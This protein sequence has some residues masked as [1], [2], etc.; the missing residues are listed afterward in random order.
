MNFKLDFQVQTSVKGHKIL[1]NLSGID[2][3]EDG[4]KSKE[5]NVKAPFKTM[6]HAILFSFVLGLFYGERK[7]FES[8]SGNWHFS[9]IQNAADTNQRYDLG[10]LLNQFGNPED[11][12]SPETARTAVMEYIN[13]G[14]HELGNH[15]FGDDDYRFAEFIKQILD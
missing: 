1:K 7:P 3:S 10:S 15:T 9:S 11:I 6:S 14:L 5:K 12:E 8:H 2:D 4:A 13:W